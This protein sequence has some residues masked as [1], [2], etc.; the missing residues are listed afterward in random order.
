PEEAEQF[1]ANF[2]FELLAPLS[3]ESVT[4]GLEPALP[5]LLAD[6]RFGGHCPRSSHPLR[7][8]FE[9]PRPGAASAVRR[10][11]ARAIIGVTDGARGAA[12]VTRFHLHR[13]HQGA[14]TELPASGTYDDYADAYA[15]YAASREQTGDDPMG[16]LP[17]MLELL[18]DLA[19]CHALD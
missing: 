15:A 12:C 3:A 11:Q 5:A 4:V 13:P 14:M 16:A 8:R 10:W 7:R 2:A 19:G 6:G 17:V 9:D 1:F 18:G